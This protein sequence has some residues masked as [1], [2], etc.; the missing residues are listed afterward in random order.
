MK[1]AGEKNKP[2]IKLKQILDKLK[3]VS[4]TLILPIAQ[5]K[6]IGLKLQINITKFRVRV[7]FGCVIDENPLFLILLRNFVLHFL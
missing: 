4:T 1:E 3:F 7:N 6:Y 2:K 5:F